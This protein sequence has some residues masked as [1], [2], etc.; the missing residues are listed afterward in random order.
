MKRLAM[1]YLLPAADRHLDR[2][3]D[4]PYA[5]PL[6]AR[7]IWFSPQVHIVVPDPRDARQTGSHASGSSAANENS[8]RS[9]TLHS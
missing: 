4:R 6:L 5:S 2:P 3:G 8:S 1:S 7:A 9:R